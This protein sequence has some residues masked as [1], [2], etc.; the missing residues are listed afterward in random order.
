MKTILNLNQKENAKHGDYIFPV[1]KYIC[2]ISS[3]FPIITPHWHE[4][5]EITLIQKGKC[6]YHI[7][8]NEYLV[9]EG[10]IIFVPPL[11]LHSA[12]ICENATMKSETYVFNFNFLGGHHTDICSIK[13]LNPITKKEILF[14]YVIKKNHIIYNELKNIFFEIDK[15]Y[16]NNTNGYELM[17][18]S[19]LLQF[20]FKLIPYAEKNTTMQNPN[21][22]KLKN[23]LDY[24]EI[25]YNKN[26][27][28]DELA[29]IAFLSKYYFMRFFKKCLGMT[30][31]EYIND[32]RL[33]NSIKLFES[34]NTSIIDVSMSV[35]FNN[36]SYFHRLFKKKYGITP[37]TFL[38]NLNK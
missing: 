36:L 21:S 25:N 8:L 32:L 11:V 29:D 37:K 24:V 12:T 34:G 35:G 20:I 26:I 4:E 27:T 6:F 3:N 14:P 10:D 2:N 28:I 13:Y 30:C 17:L 7:D 33:E 31:F 5:A 16:E 9:E 22:E 15:T 19:L 23:V 38:N 18:K 1:N